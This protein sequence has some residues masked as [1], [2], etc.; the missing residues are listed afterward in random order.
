MIIQINKNPLITNKKKIY[1]KKNGFW[2][3]NP[4]QKVKSPA[5]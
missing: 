5:S 2:D 4:S 3:L 1:K